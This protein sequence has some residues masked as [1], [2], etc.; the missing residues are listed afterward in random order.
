MTGQWAMTRLVGSAILTNHGVDGVELGSESGHLLLVLVRR[1]TGENNDWLNGLDQCRSRDSFVQRLVGSSCD[2]DDQEVGNVHED[3]CIGQPTDLLQAADDTR[4]HAD[5]ENDD[6]DCREANMSL[7]DLRDVGRFTQDQNGYREELLE[8]L[9][10]VDEVTGAF[11]K[12]SEEGVAVT[13]H[14]VT[15]RI[16]V[17]V[18]FPDGP[19]GE[20]G[21]DTEDKV[22]SDTSAVS[23]TREN[24]A[25]TMRISKCKISRSVI[26]SRNDLRSTRPTKNVSSNEEEHLTPAGSPHCTCSA[27]PFCVSGLEWISVGLL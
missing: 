4:D 11:A 9:C 12:E 26:V 22:Q 21:E 14:W 27:T 23:D 19:T 7:G 10:D 17:Q 5:A 1:L 16:E 25:I 2:H 13:H 18:D 3:G 20:S 15:G 24:E 8:R 6:H